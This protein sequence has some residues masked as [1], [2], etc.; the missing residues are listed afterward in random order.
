MRSSL[1]TLTFLWV[2]FFAPCLQD[3][4]APLWVCIWLVRGK[5]RIVR[6]SVHNGLR[7]YFLFVFFFL[8]NVNKVLHLHLSWNVA[9]KWRFPDFS[10][11]M[12]HIIWS[13]DQKFRLMS[14]V[15]SLAMTAILTYV[16]LL[17]HFRPKN[18]KFLLKLGYMEAFQFSIQ[19]NALTNMNSREPLCIK[20]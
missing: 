6:S 13:L 16:H 19:S 2:T 15:I 20:V 3:T 18:S 8:K 14:L 17:Q 12:L 11:I 10:W 9:I 1:K 4:L 7:F 5:K